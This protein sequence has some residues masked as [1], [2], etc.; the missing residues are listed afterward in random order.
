[1]LSWFAA[2]AARVACGEPA[3]PAVAVDPADRV[4]PAETPALAAIG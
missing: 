2:F 1:V 3:R 4:R